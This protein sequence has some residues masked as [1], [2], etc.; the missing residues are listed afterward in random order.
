MDACVSCPDFPAYLN[1]FWFL[2]ILLRLL[3]SEHINEKD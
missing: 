2:W 3:D 1:T